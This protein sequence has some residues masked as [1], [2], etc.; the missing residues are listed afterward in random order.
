MIIY[1]KP[2]CNERWA[3]FHKQRF[4]GCQ[5]VRWT[6]L[7]TNQENNRAF[8]VYKKV[9]KTAMLQTNSRFPPTDTV[10]MKKYA[11]YLLGFKTLHYRQA[12]TTGHVLFLLLI[13]LQSFE[14]LSRSI[15]QIN[16][17][18]LQYQ[19]ALSYARQ[20][21]IWTPVDKLDQR[22]HLI[23][24]RTGFL[25]SCK[26]ASDIPTSTHICSTSLCTFSFLPL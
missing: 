25:V 26:V 23:L 6:L 19:W 22:Q 16:Q 10:R 4:I 24:E 8:V 5:W 13:T 11:T 7:L 1:I 18:K 14:L 12:F 2:A 15:L 3:V 21:W 9:N 20:G 17:A